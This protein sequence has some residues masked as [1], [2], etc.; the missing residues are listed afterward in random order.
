MFDDH[1]PERTGTNTSSRSDPHR[2]EP[3]RVHRTGTT[4]RREQILISS[5]VRSDRHKHTSDKSA[6]KSAKKEHKYKETKEKKHNKHKKVEKEEEESED[7]SSSSTSSSTS[8]DSDSKIKERWDFM[9]SAATQAVQHFLK[10][11]QAY[12]SNI[13]RQEAGRTILQSQSP[14]RSAFPSPSLQLQYPQISQYLNLLTYLNSLNKL[15]LS[16]P[17]PTF[18]LPS[19]Q[20]LG[21]PLD[22]T[23]TSFPN[24]SL[25]PLPPPPSTTTTTSDD[26]TLALPPA[27][28]SGI[29]GDYSS[30]VA[31]PQSGSIAPAALQNY[32]TLNNTLHSLFPSL[33]HQR[34]ASFVNQVTIIINALAQQPTGS[35][36]DIR[37]WLFLLSWLYQNKLS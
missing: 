14:A 31:L 23:A 15:P 5:S 33:T 24:S 19:Y 25:L 3:V 21:Q 22:S 36:S 2:T 8:T 9:T 12:F 6:A 37:P 7:S 26:T 1:S 4:H 11:N 27:P 34:Y 17:A 28:S 10:T 35:P 29:P 32:N 13:F 16:P 20:T 30:A 18:S